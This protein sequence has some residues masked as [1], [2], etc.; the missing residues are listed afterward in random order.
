MSLQRRSDPSRRPGT[1]FRFAPP[2][3][4]ILICT[5][6]K[7]SICTPLPEPFNLIF[8]PILAPPKVGA[9]GNMSSPL[10]TLLQCHLSSQKNRPHIQKYIFYL[11]KTQKTPIS[12]Y[13]F[14]YWRHRWPT[15]LY[16]TCPVSRKVS[17]NKNDS[18]Q[19]CLWPHYPFICLGQRNRWTLLH[20]PC[21]PRG[22]DS[23]PYHSHIGLKKK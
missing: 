8:Q 19:A 1:N 16:F 17:D 20:V 11:L 13:P 9:R 3:L 4:K 2:P 18:S 6:L 21:A 5:P 12:D 10:T 15:Q 7:L 14:I 22:P 23:Q